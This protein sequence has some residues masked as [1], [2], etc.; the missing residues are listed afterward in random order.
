MP[1]KTI[2]SA[3][4]TPERVVALMDATEAITVGPSATPIKMKITAEITPIT[5]LFTIFPIPLIFVFSPNDL[6]GSIY[7]SELINK[8]TLKYC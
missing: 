8:H 4:G 1:S 5:V 7:Y 3:S 2:T 6:R